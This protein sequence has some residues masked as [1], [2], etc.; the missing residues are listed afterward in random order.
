MFDL[1][2]VGMPA[3][4]HK[5]EELTTKSITHTHTHTYSESQGNQGNG[6][7]GTHTQ[8]SRS[9]TA[10]LSRDKGVFTSKTQKHTQLTLHTQALRMLTSLTVRI[11][12]RSY[13]TVLTYTANVQC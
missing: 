8:L 7:T 13:G 12:G 11:E 5:C 4:A 1:V 10:P 6:L 2:E 9:T 3:G